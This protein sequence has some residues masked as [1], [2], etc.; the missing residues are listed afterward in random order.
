MIQYQFAVPPDETGTIHDVLAFL[1]TQGMPPALA[2]LKN[3]GFGTAG[4]LSFPIPG[5][6]LAVD[7][8]ARWLRDP[9]TL[10]PIDKLVAAAGGRVYLAKDTVSDP[11]LIPVMYPR[12]PTWRRTRRRLDPDGRWTSGLAERLGLLS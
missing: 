2:T 6:T 7:L 12:L 4:P 11:E 1:H 9:R 3:F 10:Q 8:P 5:W